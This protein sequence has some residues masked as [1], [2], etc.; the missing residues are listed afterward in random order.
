MQEVKE[1]KWEVQAEMLPDNDRSKAIKEQRAA[2]EEARQLKLEQVSSTQIIK[3]TAPKACPVT[4]SLI[5]IAL[6]W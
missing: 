2:A 3:N 1:F 4:Q 6:S 5:Q